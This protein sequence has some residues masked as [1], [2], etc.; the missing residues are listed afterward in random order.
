MK[1]EERMYVRTF[2]G[3]MKVI[4]VKVDGAMTG[5][6]NEDGNAY[7][8]NDLM[9]N[10]S[11]N[12]IDL[13]VEGDYVNGSCVLDFEVLQTGE[14]AIVVDT[15]DNYGW[16]QGIIPVNEIYSV[17]TKEQFEEMEYNV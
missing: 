12:I 9:T 16:G 15:L 10:P 3:I 6:V 5:F 1:L 2:D 14:K 4:V 11:R 8:V 7:F 17:V 13:I